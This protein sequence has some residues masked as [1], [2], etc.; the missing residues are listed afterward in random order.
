MHFIDFF[1]GM[2]GFSYGLQ[3]AG[4]TPL[5]AF[6]NEPKALHA[7]NA[8]VGRH[9]WRSDLSLPWQKEYEMRHAPDAIWVMSPPCQAFSRNSFGL[10]SMGDTRRAHLE[11]LWTTAML[12]IQRWKPRCILIENVPALRYDQNHCTRHTPGLFNQS[13]QKLEQAGYYVQ[14]AVY[15]ARDVGLA[16]NR[17]RM[18]VWGQRE[19]GPGLPEQLKTEPTPNLY[20]AIGHAPPTESGAAPPLKWPLHLTSQLSER[21]LRR[22]RSL[23]AGE[24][25]LHLREDLRAGLGKAKRLRKTAYG[26]LCWDKPAGTITTRYTDYG[27]GRHGHPEQDRALSVMEGLMLQ[28]FPPDWPLDP[29]IGIRAL[30]TLIGNAVPPPLACAIGRALA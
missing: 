18:F 26:R 16:Q 10:Y 6:D 29:Q 1:C 12:G 3:L 24:T 7:Y 2:G 28:G 13:I 11:R 4:W 17:K 8:G 25:Q 14:I 9:A 30:S 19:A 22:I 23:R 27:C 15:N 21:N 5:L 20:Q